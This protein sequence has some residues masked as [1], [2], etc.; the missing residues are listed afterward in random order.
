MT[1][2]EKAF[3]PLVSLPCWGV[4]RGYS[5]FLTFEFG[6]PSLVIREP[7]VASPG[8]SASLRRMLARRNVHARGEWHLWIYCCNWSV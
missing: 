7:I 8:A 1:V 3:V 4:K 5:T 6:N 2:I